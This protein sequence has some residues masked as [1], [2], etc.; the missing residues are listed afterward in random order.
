M[1]NM[2]NPQVSVEWRYNNRLVIFSFKES[3]KSTIEALVGKGKEILSSY[4]Q[5]QIL[6][7]IHDLS[8]LRMTH[9]IH[10]Q[11]HAQ[12]LADSPTTKSLCRHC[13][14]EYRCCEYGK[15]VC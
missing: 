10:L 7:V 13:C 9:F 14:S 4:P 1:S 12:G 8:K 11:P 6:Y 3:S 5:D 15:S 2:A